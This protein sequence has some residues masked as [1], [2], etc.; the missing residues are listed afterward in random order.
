MTTPDADALAA[1]AVLDH[2]RA[3]R[4]GVPEVVLG[5]WKP[6]AQIAAL[7]GGLAARGA[8][9]L[10]TRVDAAKAA[11]V[12]AALPMARYHAVARMLE[13]APAA[14]SGSRPPPR[15]SRCRCSPR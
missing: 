14:R 15:R 8:G 2:D 5:E 1:I 3:A 12:C 6:A 10:A 4:T 11:E 7:L 13:L 9:A